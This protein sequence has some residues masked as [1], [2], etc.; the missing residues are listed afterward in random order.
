MNGQ[1]AKLTQGPLTREALERGQVLPF[2]K[3]EGW[4]S[5]DVVRKL[6]KITGVKKVGHAGTL[7]PFA[8]GL[9]LICFGKATRRVEQL[10]GLEKEYVG[11]IELGMETDTHDVT[12]QIVATAPVPAELD[13]ERI[14]AVLSIFR[15]RIEQ[16]PP[17]FSALKHKGRKL[18][19]LARQGKTVERQARPVTIY[20]LKLLRREANE[21]D[22]QVVCS[23]GTYIRALARDIGREL[24]TG[25][26]LK[27]LIRTRIADYRLADAWDIA[28]FEKA[29]TDGNTVYG[30]IS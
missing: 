6:R 5:F 23:R 8:T 27:S 18:Y 10:M 21:L 26:Y 15:G 19:E 22:V 14:E 4:T 7:D 17:M 30:R 20:K 12:G 28:A 2:N 16:V 29:L 3:P 11:T 1:P 24:R 13:D 25:A 9:L